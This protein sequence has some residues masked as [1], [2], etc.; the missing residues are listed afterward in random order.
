MLNI[1]SKIYIAGHEGLVG[2]ALMRVCKKYGFANLITRS[3]R[4]LDL[5]DQKAVN[6]FFRVIR[7]EYIF[8]AAAKVGGIFANIQ[9]PASFLFDNTLIACNVIDAAY[10]Y[11]AKKLLFLGSSCIYPRNCPQ[12]IKE[13]YLLSDYLEQT[14]EAYAI[15]KITGIKLCQAYNKQ[16]GTNFISCMPTN[17][18]G[19]YDNFDLETAHV[20]PALIRKCIDAKRAGLRQVE[21]WGSGEPHRDFL[22]VDDV[23]EA[24]LFLMNHYAAKKW[25][26][27]GSGVDISI[28]ELACMIKDIVG[29]S[30][31]IYFNTN[32]PNG[33]PRKLLDSSK[34]T[35]LGWRPLYSLQEGLR[36]TV[37]WYYQSDCKGSKKY[38][39]LQPQ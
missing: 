8:L 16:Y 21:V 18:Y 1:D 26:N 22:F 27:I 37:E 2:R 36:E 20:I 34:I 33:T 17:L 9:Y 5:R 24:C 38:A 39:A 35:A 15:A 14:N 25:I 7:P 23:A 28:K 12:P 6:Q 10:R 30:G 11:E 13:E 19:P 3:L 31:S 32:K 29:F 4:E